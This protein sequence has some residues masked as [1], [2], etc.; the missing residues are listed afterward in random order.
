MSM[1]QLLETI[2]RFDG[3][4]ELAP[5][6]GSPFPEIA[7]GD[8]FFYF[9]PNGQVPQREQPY[10]TIV[11]KNY[12]DDTSCDLDQPDRWRLNIHVGRSIFIELLGEDSQLD[13]TAAVDFTAIDT[14][15]PHP[16]YRAQGWISI[17]NPGTQTYS[18]AIGLLGRAHD[19]ARQR[20]ARRTST[21]N[22]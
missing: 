9:A 11:T 5:T 2:R 15:L 4:F 7:W 1:D 20:A 13:S 17:T 6:P 10:G 18:L 8:H 16:A 3:F 21:S 22:R 12:P 14:V 19:A